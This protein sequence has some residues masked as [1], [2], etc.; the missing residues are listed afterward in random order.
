MITRRELFKL[1]GATLAAGALIR[2]DRVFADAEPEKPKA[3]EE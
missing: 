3:G 1:G 2:P